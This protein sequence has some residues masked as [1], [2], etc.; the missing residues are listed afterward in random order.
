MCVCVM[1]KRGKAETAWYKF[2]VKLFMNHLMN[3]VCL[4]NARNKG[5]REWEGWGR[6][7]SVVS[8]LL[9]LLTFPLKHDHHSLNHWITTT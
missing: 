2:I 5:I 8:E 4:S 9:W 6:D 3:C 7:S 1:S